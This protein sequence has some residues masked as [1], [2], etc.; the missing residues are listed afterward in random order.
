MSASITTSIA[1]NNPL[2][3]SVLGEAVVGAGFVVRHGID[4][5]GLLTRGLV[6]P[7]WAIWLDT[8]SID[9]VITGWTAAAG[10]AGSSSVI[11]TG[12]SPSIYGY[13][14]EVPP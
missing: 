11:T 7:S 3:Y 10:Y 5:A 14:G 8:Q 9:G 13:N 6:W 1:Q 12:W 2:S 4:G